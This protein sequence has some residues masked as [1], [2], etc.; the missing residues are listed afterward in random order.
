M[1]L[2]ISKSEYLVTMEWEYK[3]GYSDK[4]IELWNNSRAKELLLDSVLYKAIKKNT[5]TILYD[6]KKFNEIQEFIESNAYEEFLKSIANYMD[7]DMH[8]GIYGLV[9]TVLPRKQYIPKS[10]YMQLRTI[11][12]PL[13]DIDPYLKWRKER[14]FKFVE[15]NNKVK[16]F[17]SFH[18][19]FATN[20]GVLFVTE[21]EGDPDEYRNSFLT[22]EYQV[23]IKEAGH[24]H[25]KGGKGGLNTFEY[26]L[27]SD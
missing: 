3:D 13:S 15:K 18:S 12:V 5:M 20:P 9:N 16:S 14:I 10:K 21:F 22:P 11:E 6:V 1:N 27:V 7:S 19:V 8:Q 26:E 24:D 23:I 17:L 2:E 25:I 4:I